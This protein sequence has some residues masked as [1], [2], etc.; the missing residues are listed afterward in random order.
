VIDRD[1]RLLEYHLERSSGYKLLDEE[2][3]AMIERA[4]PLPPIPGDPE[5]GR[6]TYQVPVNFNLR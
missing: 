2:V 5:D 3:A 1:G 4:S 6:F